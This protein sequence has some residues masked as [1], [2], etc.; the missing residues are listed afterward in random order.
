[1]NCADLEIL[2]CDYVDGTLHGEEKSA[3]E[4]HLAVC[5]ACAEMAKDAAGA[6]TFM[7]RVATVEPPP[8]LLTRI[9]FE[10]PQSKRH[11]AQSRSGW[12]RIK[13]AWIDPILQPR[14][15]MGMAMTVLSFAMIG[16][17]AGI[18]VKQLKPSDLNP[19]Q[20]WSAL[21]DKSLRTWERGV[22]YYDSLR[23]VYEIQTRL[24]DW[25]EQ[26]DADRNARTTSGKADGKAV[27]QKTGA[28]KEQQK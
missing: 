24:K 16:R 7:A 2:L 6:V 14:F 26:A 13:A 3:L 18:E 28:V 12:S 1:M 19:V 8:E 5:P 15:A 17:F 27:P 4:A 10:L 9:L 21:E 25:G 22:K 23:L 11:E 20:V